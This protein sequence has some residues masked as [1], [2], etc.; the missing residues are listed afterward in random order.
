MIIELKPKELHEWT[1][2]FGVERAVDNILSG[3]T[4]LAQVR[5]RDNATGLA[6][7]ELVDA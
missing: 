4:Y 7:L 2:I 5:R 3:K 6:S 1:I